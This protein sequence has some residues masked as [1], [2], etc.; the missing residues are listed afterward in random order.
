M[1]TLGLT[2]VPCKGS[3]GDLGPLLGAFV[4]DLGP[5][6]LAALGIALGSLGLV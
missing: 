4:G 1:G 5:L 6:L 2:E 3:V